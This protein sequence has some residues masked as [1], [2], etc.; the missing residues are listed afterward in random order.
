MAISYKISNL[1]PEDR[2]D[3]LDFIDIKLKKHKKEGKSMETISVKEPEP[4]YR[5]LKPASIA[6]APFKYTL[7]PYF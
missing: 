7:F 4:E 3:I 6:G 1:S 2:Q 5:A